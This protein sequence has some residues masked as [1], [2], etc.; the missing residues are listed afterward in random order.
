[1]EIPGFFHWCLLVWFGS[2]LAPQPSIVAGKPCIRL[3]AHPGD[4][5]D[6][7]LVFFLQTVLRNP[8][9][10]IALVESPKI[11]LQ[12]RTLRLSGTAYCGECIDTPTPRYLNAISACRAAVCACWRW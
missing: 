1:M 10:T 6:I 3:A 8:S 5:P 7:R 4:S 11:S 12:P 2:S 9:V